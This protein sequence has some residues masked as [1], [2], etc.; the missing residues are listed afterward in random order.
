M[1][2]LY[3]QAPPALIGTIVNAAIVIAVFGP[4]LAPA[5][6]GG[7]FLAVVLIVLARYWDARAYRRREPPGAETPA[8]GRRYLLGVLANGLAWGAA[9]F[10]FYLEHSE[11]HQVFL[12][13]VLGGMTAGGVA[14][15][16]SVRYAY[17]AFVIPA[18]V[19]YTARLLGHGGEHQLAMGGMATLYLGMLA[20]IA[21][22][23]YRTVAEALRL[24]FENLD[25]VGELTRSR[26][27]LAVANQDLAAQMAKKLE[28]E[29][30]L[31]AAY[32]ELERRVLERT[33]ALAS[34][35]AALREAHRRKDEF[36]AVLGHELRNPLAPIRNAVQ[37]MRRPGAP[38]AALAWS[39]EVIDR[40]VDHI[41]R[42]VD[43]LLDV[44]RIVQ[45]KVHLQLTTLD[46]ASVVGQALEASRPLIEARG[47]ELSVRTPQAPVVVRGDPVRLAQ[48]ICNLL[49]NAAKYTEPGG[50]IRLEVEPSGPWVEVRVADNGVG[51]PA[52]LLPHVFDLFTQAGPSL[53]RAEGG[54]GIGLTL[55]KRLVEM[56]GGRVEVRSDGEGRGSEFRVRLPR[57]SVPD[58]RGAR[59]SPAGTPG[60]APGTRVLVV[61]DSPDIAESLAIALRLE[62]HEVRTAL[63][64]A[65]AL[66]AAEA[67]APEV[68]LLDIG[69]PDVD[70]YQVA[71]QLRGRAATRHA[72]IVA[73]S[74]SARP[75]ERER[76]RAAGFDDFLAKPVDFLALARVLAGPGDPPAGSPAVLASQGQ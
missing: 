17:L 27:R 46:L 63:D 39:R 42:L 26:D 51:I 15:L 74:G 59:A 16:A 37:V 36:L 75:E 11:I 24:R 40:Q 66:A 21:E 5:W 41:T 68:V 53:A 76:A 3:Q 45:G 50:R 72:R 6:L 49:N 54:M 60:P 14:T 7:W 8:W 32:A 13:F 34:S 43:D 38:E 23:L 47:H 20:M 25:L 64:G 19:P 29:R 33:E 18:L 58:T 55:V 52:T 73:V 57:W 61:D 10:F 2:L 56:H 22:R 31:Q 70:G 4:V 62:G 35:E 44:S 12:A 30:A 65:A 1:S 48:V 9:G 69:M 71:G 67:F 28:A